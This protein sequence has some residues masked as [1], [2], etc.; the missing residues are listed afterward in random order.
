MDDDDR[1]DYYPSP[2]SRDANT[3]AGPEKAKDHGVRTRSPLRAEAPAGDQAQEV[4]NPKKLRDSL[5]SIHKLR[6]GSI[7]IQLPVSAGAEYHKI[8]DSSDESKESKDNS[9][10]DAGPL[11]VDRAPKL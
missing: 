5:S 6:E 2:E 1:T 3:P 10:D 7:K 9:E 4:V 11:P 8:N